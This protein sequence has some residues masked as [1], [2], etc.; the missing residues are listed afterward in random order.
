MSEPGLSD[1]VVLPEHRAGDGFSL[2]EQVCELSLFRAIS[3]YR[4]GFCDYL[5]QDDLFQAD[6]IRW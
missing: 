4:K 6:R 1:L 2:T 5:F 3:S